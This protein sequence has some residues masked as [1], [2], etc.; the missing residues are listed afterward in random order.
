MGS[1]FSSSSSSTK[2]TAGDRRI[3]NPS[4]SGPIRYRRG[5]I[6]RVTIRPPVG[7]PHEDVTMSAAELRAQR[8]YYQPNQ[9]SNAPSTGSRLNSTGERN[10]SESY[11]EFP[12]LYNIQTPLVTVTER[13]NPVT[14]NDTPQASTFGFISSAPSEPLPPSGPSLSPKQR[15]D[16]INARNR[17]F[18]TANQETAAAA[19]RVAAI[20][21]AALPAAQ[22][23]AAIKSTT[24]TERGLFGGNQ[25]KRRK[26]K[27]HHNRSRRRQ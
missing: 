8:K 14:R 27:N 9:S 23:R 25:T 26:H 15:N 11:Q 12:S 5:G 20:A 2:R 3:N 24:N 16:M 4:F 6:A 21:D 7:P 1:W 18:K 10:T 19:G 13:S 17:R 22:T